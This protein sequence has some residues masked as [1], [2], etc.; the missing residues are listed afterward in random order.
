[1]TRRSTPI[2]ATRGMSDGTFAM[3]TRSAIQRDE[4]PE[5][6]SGG[7]QGGAL[8]HEGAQHL[9]SPGADGDAERQLALP[10]L[11]PDEEE[12][13]DVRARDQEDEADRAEQ[14][15]ER[16]AHVADDRLVQRHDDRL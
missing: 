8:A 2:S 1:M 5:H 12:V 15:P 7:G 3:V 9:G 13:R 6:A 16:A 11:G 4:D 10:S 14:D